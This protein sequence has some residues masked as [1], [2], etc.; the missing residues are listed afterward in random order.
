MYSNSA[1]S[2]VYLDE[3]ALVQ[4]IL[5]K[6][7][8]NYNI[9]NYIPV[10]HTHIHIYIVC[11]QLNQLHHHYEGL[12]GHYYEGLIGHY[13]SSDSTF[14][15]II[16]FF[17]FFFLVPGPKSKSRS[18][19]ESTNITTGKDIASLVSLSI[20]LIFCNTINQRALLFL[21]SWRD[22]V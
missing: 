6:Y 18:L 3:A 20:S 8:Y 10:W 12:I 14:F 1:N 11:I 5:Y 21:Y 4:T 17:S 19:V 13:Y 9:Y 7:M 2:Y 16:I 15:F 22:L